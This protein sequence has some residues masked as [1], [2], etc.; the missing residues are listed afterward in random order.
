MGTG[1]AFSDSP[2]LSS[3]SI[4]A[5]LFQ[6]CVQCDLVLGET[7]VHIHSFAVY[8]DEMILLREWGL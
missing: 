7:V 2:F 8:V 1:W 6:I 4:S 5:S 3:L